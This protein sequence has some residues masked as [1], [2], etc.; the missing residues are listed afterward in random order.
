[1]STFLPPHLQDLSM[2]N[3]EIS[4]L[5]LKGIRELSCFPSS[6]D[7]PCGFNSVAKAGSIHSK[8]LNISEVP[9]E[10]PGTKIAKA[11]QVKL[12]SRGHDEI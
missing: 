8:F 6:R 12:R 11:D 7:L 9:S 5:D 1:M 4:R 10:S 3:G 2:P